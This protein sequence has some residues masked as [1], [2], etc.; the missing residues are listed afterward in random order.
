VSDPAGPTPPN[1]PASKHNPYHDERGR[2]TT[3]DGAADGLVHQVARSGGG[4]RPPPRPPRPPPRSSPPPGIGHNRPPRDP[5]PPEAIQRAIDD[6]RFI[7]DL[8]GDDV[9]AH[10]PG[11]PEGSQFGVNSRAN[12]YT[13]ADRAAADEMR[14]RLISN[15]PDVMEAETISAMPRNAVY[16]AE[17]TLLL[18]AARANGGSLAGLEIE[19]H[20][21]GQTVCNHCQRILPYVGLELGNPT[22]TFIGPTGLRDT[23]RNGAWVIRSTR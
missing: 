18:R 6:H 3:A 8:S 15:Y 22:V 10:A 16:H 2:F 17:T 9:V 20:V 14:S 12:S 1:D 7:H 11:L 4:Q 23:M 5:P 21:D 19:V 13:P